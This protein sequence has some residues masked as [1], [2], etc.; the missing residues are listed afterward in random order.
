MYRQFWFSP[1]VSPDHPLLSRALKESI[2]L[3]GDVE[4]FARDNTKPVLAVTGSN[5]KSTVVTLLELMAREEGIAVALAGNIGRPLLDSVL[6]DHAELYVLELS[7][8]QLD[9]T[10]SLQASV[11]CIL[12]ISPDHLD[13]YESFEAYAASKQTIYRNAKCVVVNRDDAL[14]WSQQDSETT[15]SFGMDEPEPGQFG[16][17]LIRDEMFLCQGSEV[18]VAAKTCLKHGHTDIQNALAAMSIA[19]CAGISFESM[20]TVL[21]TFKGLA[22]RCEWL[23]DIDGVRWIN[24]S[25]G[26]NVGATLAA[27]KL[28]R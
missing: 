18:I 14:T 4:L 8:F 13:R 12:N 7:S 16:I 23:A 26:T 21:S 15:V 9:V 6:D 27:L 5:A 19:Y 3:I 28:L 10:S 2:E 25:K 1:G 11:A 22:H 24:D 20:R 17:R